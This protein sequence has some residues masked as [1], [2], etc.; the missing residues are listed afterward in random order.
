MHPNLLDLNDTVL[1]VVD[2]QEPFLRTIFER[3][4]VVENVLKMVE[5]AKVLGLPVVTTLQNKARMG[6]VIPE[7]AK[8]LPSGERFDKMTFSCCGSDDFICEISKIGRKTA[9]ICGIETHI[10]VN[11]TSHDLVQL[12]YNVH[13]VADAVS[14]RK[15][16]DWLTGLEKMRQAGIVITSVE[17]SIFELLRDASLP[18]FKAILNLVK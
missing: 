17:M 14:S 6:D 1:I 2:V 9:L 11:Q 13:V 18:E 3:E 5:A 8:A 10:C 7:I 12:G 15:Q 4:R 16:Q